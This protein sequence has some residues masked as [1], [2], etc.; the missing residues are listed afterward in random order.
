MRL[1]NA[2]KSE[3]LRAVDRIDSEYTARSRA[4]LACGFKATDT[5]TKATDRILGDGEVWPK[6]YTAVV[7]LGRHVQDAQLL[8]SPEH[9][10]DQKD[11]TAWKALNREDT[12]VELLAELSGKSTIQLARARGRWE[13][14]LERVAKRREEAEEAPEAIPAPTP[15][16]EPKP[17]HEAPVSAVVAAKLLERIRAETVATAREL[18]TALANGTPGY[19]KDVCRRVRTYQAAALAILGDPQDTEQPELGL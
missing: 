2:E 8:R 18:D 4:S 13:R 17:A 9:H 15:T 10:R 16:P 1:T 14:I 11:F 12:D 3:F 5:L 19:L 7:R 6:T